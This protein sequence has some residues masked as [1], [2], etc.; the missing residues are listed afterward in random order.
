MAL[1]KCPDC[2]REVSDR[3]PAC[4]HCG[5]PIGPTR[6]A[7]RG[8]QPAVEP[9]RAQVAT[10][11]RKCI[12]CGS[13]E[14]TYSDEKQGLGAG[15]AFLGAVAIGPLG[16]LAG[17]INRKKSR[18]LVRCNHCFKQFEA[19]KLLE[20][21]KAERAAASTG[22][23]LGGLLVIALVSYFALRACGGEPSTVGSRAAE[24]AAPVRPSS[25]TDDLSL[26]VSKYGPPDVD[27]STLNDK[28]RPPMVTRWLVYK[29]EHVRATYLPDVAVGTPPPYNR[30]KLVGFQDERNNAVLQASEVVARLKG[31]LRL[32]K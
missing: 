11:P 27:D 20:A 1:I 2:G 29:K 18:V 8:E 7:L 30:W 10:P 6:T 9:Q 23:T 31:R 17:A 13:T 14:L 24:M 22:S 5:G 16:L 25:P 32:G 15:K 28:P 3:A 21:P 19:G 26:F 4:P 12:H